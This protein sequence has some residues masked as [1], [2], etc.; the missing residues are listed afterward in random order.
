MGFPRAKCR[1][2]LLPAGSRG[3]LLILR[4]QSLFDSRQEALDLAERVMEVLHVGLHHLPHIFDREADRS[5]VFSNHD[6][7]FLL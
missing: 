5:Y 2:T 4:I 6:V 3:I 1:P 7:P